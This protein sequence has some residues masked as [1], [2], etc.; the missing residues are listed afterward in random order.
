MARLKRNERRVKMLREN[1]R[2]RSGWTVSADPTHYAGGRRCICGRTIY[3]AFEVRSPHGG[4]TF[5]G[6]RCA[7][8]ALIWFNGG[9][10]S[11]DG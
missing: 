9:L 3:N 5:L 6:V 11:I 8:S 10:E 1:L 2:N 7:I 4:V